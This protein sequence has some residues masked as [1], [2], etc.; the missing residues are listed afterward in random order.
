M[1]TPR[2]PRPAH[3]HARGSHSCHAVAQCIK[4][5]HDKEQKI[6]TV[7]AD[8]KGQLSEEMKSKV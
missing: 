3:V 6:L 1:R 5:L 8:A 7:V 4:L 2:T